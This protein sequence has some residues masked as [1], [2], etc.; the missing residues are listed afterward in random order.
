LFATGS[1]AGEPCARGSSNSGVGWSS[2][3]YPG[4]GDTIFTNSGLT[5]PVAISGYFA[6]YVPNIPDPTYYGP[7]RTISGNTVGSDSGVPQC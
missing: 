5:T 2:V 3:Q 1:T 7:T 4:N 6:L